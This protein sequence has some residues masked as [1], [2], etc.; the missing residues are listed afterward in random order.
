LAR[1]RDKGSR[2][3]GFAGVLLR[4]VREQKAEDVSSFCFYLV[5]PVQ[6]SAGG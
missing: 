4:T 1:G 3:M 2:P 6:Q 5:F